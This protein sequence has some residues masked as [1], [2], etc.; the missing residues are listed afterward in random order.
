MAF[1]G[2]ANAQQPPKD[3]ILL[4][5]FFGTLTPVKNGKALTLAELKSGIDY[6]P[7]AKK[8]IKKSRR[9]KTLA[10]VLNVLAIAPFSMAVASTNSS[11]FWAGCLV[12]GGLL[13]S[14]YLLIDG[15][16]NQALLQGFK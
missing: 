12:A 3:S 15:P 8:W 13:G 10:T 2:F 1:S 6:K 9:I 11:E 5:D 14:S 7:E 4:V 16:F